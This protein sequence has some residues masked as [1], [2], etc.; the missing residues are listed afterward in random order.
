VSRPVR[1]AVALAAVVLTYSMLRSF[2]DRFVY[3]PMRYPQG[4]WALQA[5]VGA[6]DRW[7]MTADGTRLNG[8]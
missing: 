7:L 3:Y 8:W 1:S 6:E 4:A 5:R 2:A